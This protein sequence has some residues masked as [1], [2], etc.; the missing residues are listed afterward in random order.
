MRVRQIFSR[1]SPR[2]RNVVLVCAFTLRGPSLAGRE[3][4][5]VG[6]TSFNCHGDSHVRRETLPSLSAA[7]CLLAARL[8]NFWNGRSSLEEGTDARKD[9]RKVVFPRK[10]ELFARRL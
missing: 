2:A 9:E 4:T 7:P 3:G 10:F 6:L 5:D 8:D 1:V